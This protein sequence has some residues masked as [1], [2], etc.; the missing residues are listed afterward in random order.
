MG[1]DLNSRPPVCE[2]GIITSLDHPSQILLIFSQLISWRIIDRGKSLTGIGNK[3]KLKSFQEMQNQ[4]RIDSEKNK[5]L[6]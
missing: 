4:D 1:R 3:V 2:T 5:T 6:N